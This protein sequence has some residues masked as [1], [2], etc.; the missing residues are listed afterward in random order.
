MLAT[1]AQVEEADGTVLDVV[2]RGGAVIPGGTALQI[3]QALDTSF[4][5]HGRKCVGPPL[6]LPPPPI[7]LRFADDL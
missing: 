4:W 6:P 1:N 5:A 7:P 3:A 2:M